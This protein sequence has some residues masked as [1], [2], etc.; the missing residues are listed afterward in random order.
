MAI[1]TFYFCWKLFGKVCWKNIWEINKIFEKKKIE[2]IIGRTKGNKRGKREWIIRFFTSQIFIAGILEVNGILK[3]FKLFL[4]FFTLLMFWV[5]E[6][7]FFLFNEVYLMVAKCLFVFFYL[8]IGSVIY[9]LVDSIFENKK[10]SFFML[11]ILEK[12]LYEN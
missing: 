9:D 7:D 4:M 12:K 3:R 2:G 8:K 11:W 10:T 5:N 1:Y 6:N